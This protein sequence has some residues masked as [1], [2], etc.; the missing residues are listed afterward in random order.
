MQPNS[1]VS[2]DGLP[3]QYRQSGTTGHA[4]RTIAGKVS[5]LAH[6]RDFLNTKHMKAF[7]ELSEEELCS[8]RLFQEYGTYLSEFARNRRNKVKNIFVLVKYCKHS[9][10]LT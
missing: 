1:K 10:K 3:A 6:F 4:S 2:A 5:A 7:A 8:I 9:T